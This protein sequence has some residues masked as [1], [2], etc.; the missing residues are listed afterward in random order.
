MEIG[1]LCN[2]CGIRY[3]KPKS[4][5]GEAM[6]AIRDILNKAKSEGWYIDWENL[7]VTC[8][9]CLKKVEEKNEDD[10]PEIITEKFYVHATKEEIADKLKDIEDYY[11]FE[12]SDEVFQ[13]LCYIGYEVELEVQINPRTGEY[14]V[15]SVGDI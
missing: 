12:F 6:L 8:P 9:E 5:E 14:V 2:E 3:G 10:M 15:L 4:I 1:I 7:N 13:N 11:E